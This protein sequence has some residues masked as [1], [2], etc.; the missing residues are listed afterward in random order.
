M[1]TQTFALIGLVFSIQATAG[2]IYRCKQPDG[3]ITYSHA[4][5]ENYVVMDLPADH[6][7]T[8]EQV[9]ENDLRIME[10]RERLDAEKLRRYR[11][12]LDGKY[13]GGHN[14]YESEYSYRYNGP[15]NPDDRWDDRRRRDQQDRGSSLQAPSRS[16]SH[17]SERSETDSKPRRGAATIGSGQA[18]H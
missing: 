11:L 6:R 8:P 12:W 14:T 16:S 13:L 5:C 1:K 17:G 18:P 4:Q 7:P 9:M 15:I 3:S 2:D 10:E